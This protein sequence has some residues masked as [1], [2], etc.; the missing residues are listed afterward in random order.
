MY[1]CHFLVE[2]MGDH[3]SLQKKFADPVDSRMARST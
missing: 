1:D 2:A 3:R